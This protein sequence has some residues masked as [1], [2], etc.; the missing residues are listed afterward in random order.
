[1]LYCWPVLCVEFYD[2][3]KFGL[4]STMVVPKSF[5]YCTK[6]I[7]FMGAFWFWIGWSCQNKT[8]HSEIIAVE[9]TTAFPTAQEW[10]C[11]RGYPFNVHP[12][13]LA[14]KLTLHTPCK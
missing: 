5:F 4:Y 14:A 8:I 7:V 6:K 1:L 12:H 11:M 10:V 13:S 2:L 9:N 3:C